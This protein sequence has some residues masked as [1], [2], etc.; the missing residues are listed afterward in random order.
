[1]GYIVDI[2]K[3]QGLINW[4]VAA[5]QIDF[6]ILKASGGLKEDPRYFQNSG[7]CER[8]EIPFAV[9]HYLTA[10]STEAA[11]KE[12]RLFYDISHVDRPHSFVVDVEDASV[13]VPT[14]KK[15]VQ[16]FVEELRKLGARRIA[17]YTGE[18]AYG[19]YNLYAS[20]F[21]WIW[22]A[23]YGKNSGRPETPP[24]YSYDLWQY[25]SRGRIDGITENTVDLS[26]TGRKGIGYFT[27][28]DS[29]DMPKKD[30]VRYLHKGHM[31][32][33]VRMLQKMLNA[34]NHA[35]LETDGVFGELTYRAV[36][37]YQ[38]GHSLAIDG[39]VGPATWGSLMEQI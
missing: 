37:N 30:L 36:K 3:H 34:V 21:D 22:I 19:N 13:P 12:A 6:A 26:V 1:M 31:G 32:E 39:I 8:L 16:A 23:K 17:L 15:I 25:T 14:A 24:R 4:D 38:R 10:N 5:K 35:G 20:D 27:N 29:C 9:Y 7:E 18:W 33:D 28:P 2:S 11:R